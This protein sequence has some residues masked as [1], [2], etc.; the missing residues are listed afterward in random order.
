MRRRVLP[1]S[2]VP[3]KWELIKTKVNCLPIYPQQLASGDS[4]W[5]PR[6]DYH[7]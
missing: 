3:G 2:K 5:C 6:T 1:D 7:Y 4:I